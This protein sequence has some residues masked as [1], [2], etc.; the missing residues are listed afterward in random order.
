MTWGQGRV[1]T[2]TLQAYGK[3]LQC[4]LLRVNESNPPNCFRSMTY[5]LICNDPGGISW[6]GTGKSHLR[7]CE[8]INSFWPINHDMMVL[9]TCK[10]YQTA[11]L[12][13]SHD[14]SICTQR[15]YSFLGQILKFTYLGN[16][17][18]GYL[19]WPLVSR[20][21]Q[22][23]P[24]SKKKFLTKA[25]GL[26]TNYPTPFAVCRY[27]SWFSRFDGGSK[28]PPSHSEPFWARPE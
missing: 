14:A 22:Y 26:P 18:P 6:Q 20:C 21:P 25:I 19:L 3:I 12:V 2:F 8:V 13:M 28:R 11:R 15:D 5:Y 7:S 24:D 17:E 1:V 4:I 16:Y 27:D 23:W 9:K 10:W